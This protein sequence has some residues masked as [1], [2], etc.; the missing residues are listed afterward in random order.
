MCRFFR[1]DGAVDLGDQIAKTH[2]DRFD[3]ADPIAEHWHFFEGAHEL[4]PI[5]LVSHWNELL[6]HRS[7]FVLQ[8]RPAPQFE[9]QYLGQLA[10]LLA[11]APVR[12]HDGQEN[13]DHQAARDRPSDSAWLPRR[14]PRYAWGGSC[15]TRWPRSIKIEAVINGLAEGVN[16]RVE[17]VAKI[18][19]IGHDAHERRRRYS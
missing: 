16:L 1:R 2:D 5:E 10:F 6:Q 18:S 9:N 4:V 11:E 7:D 13:L 14:S 15:S 12:L 19:R 8:E 3:L 17:H